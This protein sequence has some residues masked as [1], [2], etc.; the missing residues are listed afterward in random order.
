MTYRFL[1]THAHIGEIELISFGQTVELS[2]ELAADAVR[3]GC[4]LEP[5]SDFEARFSKEEM[6]APYFRMVGLHES[7]APQSFRDKKRAALLAC[8]AWREKLNQPAAEVLPEAA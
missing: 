8:H 1:G 2:D 4:T 7:N 6:A 3:G 5:A